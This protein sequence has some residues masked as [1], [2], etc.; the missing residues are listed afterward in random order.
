MKILHCV[1]AESASAK[2]SLL[3]YRKQVFQSAAKIKLLTAMVFLLPY[4][5][6]DKYM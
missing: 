4:C 2:L 5:L 3:Y 1:H 6:P